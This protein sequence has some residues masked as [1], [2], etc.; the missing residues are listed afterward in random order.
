MNQ[1]VYVT[2]LGAVSPVGLDL[3]STWESLILGKSG[4]NQISSFETSE[5]LTT[6]AA[7]ITDFDPIGILGLKESAR[8]DRF[9]QLACVASL[10]AVSNSNLE[11][12]S[13]NCM[14]F[15]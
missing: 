14:F 6:I 15:T 10:E 12:N 5:L 13:S 9:V 8:I 11:I 2:G 4:I 1:R 3:D 7:E